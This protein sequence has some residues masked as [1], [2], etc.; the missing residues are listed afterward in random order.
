MSRAFHEAAH[1]QKEPD[2]GDQAEGLQAGYGGECSPYK[3]PR[4][5][6][7]Q[8]RKQQRA[9]EKGETQLQ[10]QSVQNQNQAE[11]QEYFEDG[12]NGSKLLLSFGGP[13]QIIQAC[14]K[15]NVECKL[16]CGAWAF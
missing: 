10:T 5:Q 13:S 2:N 12:G 4:T 9:H 16:N 11:D 15:E 6:F 7:R 14:V 1:D 8:N 3:F